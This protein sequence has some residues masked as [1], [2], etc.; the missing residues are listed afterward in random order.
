MLWPCL[1]MLLEVQAC[2]ERKEPRQKAIRGHLQVYSVRLLQMPLSQGISMTFIRVI[3]AGQLSRGARKQMGIRDSK[4][5]EVP[6]HVS[7]WAASFLRSELY[8]LRE[9]TAITCPEPEIC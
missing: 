6:A 7:T 9:D 1:P 5:L 2:I 8:I 4:P 3:F